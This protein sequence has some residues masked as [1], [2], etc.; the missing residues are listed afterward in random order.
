MSRLPSDLRQRLHNIFAQ[1]ERE[2]DLLY[3]E[4]Q[5]LQEKLNLTHAD[6][7][8][9]EVSNN[10]N[11]NDTRLEVNMTNE[12]S[13]TKKDSITKKKS[14]KN[15][16]NNNTSSSSNGSSPKSKNPKQQQSTS[17]TTSV[18]SS[19]VTTAPPSTSSAAPASSVFINNSLASTLT[20]TA[21]SALAT[22]SSSAKSAILSSKTRINNLSFPKFKPNAREFIMQSIKNTSAQLVNKTTL[23]HHNFNSK[24][25]CSLSGHKD[26]IWDISLI[27]IPSSLLSQNGGGGAGNGL[28]SASSSNLSNYYNHYNTYNHG[29]NASSNL[30]V[31]TASADNTARLWYLNS[32][33]SNQQQPMTNFQP[34]SPLQQQQQNYSVLPNSGQQLTTTA[35]CIQ[36][37]SG[38]TGI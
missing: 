30:L 9:D 7:D 12:K 19:I 28:A 1:I 37:Y 2:F 13:P 3:A 24:L 29:C 16:T 23:S 11:N 4:N 31:G 35:F 14:K 34:M 10:N 26:G 20:N 8:T 17:L 5:R 18:S 21:A 32:H 38:H 6:V 22:T 36:E 15:D 33:M 25:Q 27:Q